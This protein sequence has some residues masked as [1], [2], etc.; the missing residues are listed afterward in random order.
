M[1]RIL[2]VAAALC[3]PSLPSHAELIVVLDGKLHAVPSAVS[4][5]PRGRAVQSRLAGATFVKL[6]R[7]WKGV[8]KSNSFF[9][10]HGPEALPAF[11][12]AKKGAKPAVPKPEGCGS[13]PMTWLS[14]S[15]VVGRLKKKAAAGTVFVEV[16][17]GFTPVTDTPPELAEALKQRLAQGAD[18][19][20]ASL[21]TLVDGCLRNTRVF[22]KAGE[23]LAYSSCVDDL[24]ETFRIFHRQEGAAWTWVE[25]LTLTDE[26]P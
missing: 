23:Q 4:P 3:V 16:P 26:C 18:M 8:Q 13:H 11:A 5:L 10:L 17:A 19:D 6:E 9:F 21:K 7:D 14:K 25:E 24:N 1:R 12:L 20:D 2:L 15:T 22:T